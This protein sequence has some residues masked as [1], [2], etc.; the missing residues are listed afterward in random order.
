MLR[1]H[2]TVLVSSV[3]TVGGHC[4]ETH[5]RSISSNTSVGRFR[6]LRSLLTFAI[7]SWE[8]LQFR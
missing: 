1:R 7:V 2:L 6:C 4:G 8:S 3:V 5:V